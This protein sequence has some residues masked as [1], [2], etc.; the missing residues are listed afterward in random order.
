MILLFVLLLPPACKFQGS[1]VTS[2]EQLTPAQPTT[3]QRER[4]GGRRAVM[5][6]CLDGVSYD[7]P[8]IDPPEAA[9]RNA[10]LQMQ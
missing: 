7:H 2:M 6:G 8:S 1:P 4:E 3:Q 9:W 5:N 10:I